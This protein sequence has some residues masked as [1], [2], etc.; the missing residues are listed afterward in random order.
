MYGVRGGRDCSV[1]EYKLNGDE[2]GIR[3][4]KHTNQERCKCND[5]P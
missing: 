1:T 2:R 5:C 3:D 4:E